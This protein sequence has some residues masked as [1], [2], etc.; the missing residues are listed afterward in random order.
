MRRI[1]GVMAVLMLAG[2]AAGVR[3]EDV[4]VSTYYPSPRGVYQELRVANN[5]QLA[6]QAGDVELGPLPPAGGE[7]LRIDGG[8]RVKNNAVIQGVVQIVGGGPQQNMCLKATDNN[9]NATWGYAT[10]A[11]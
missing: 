3:A 9:G 10:Y 1:H 5:T 6:M 11:P 2:G 7:R 4:T 8:I